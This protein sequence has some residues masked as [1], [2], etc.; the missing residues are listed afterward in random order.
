MNNTK[1]LELITMLLFL[2]NSTACKQSPHYS[3]DTF[4]NLDKGIINRKAI[5]VIPNQGCP[6]CI[7]TAENFVIENAKKQT[8]ILFIF[9]RIS[10]MKLLRSK[11]GTEILQLENV[12]FDNKNMIEFLDDTKE[13]YPMIIFIHHGRIKKIKYQSPSEEGFTELSKS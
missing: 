5:V 3:I 7:S 8:D 4:K 2:M 9:T 10:S 6:G 1:F 12:I 11:L 13:I